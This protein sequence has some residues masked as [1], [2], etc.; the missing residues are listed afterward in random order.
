MSA[1]DPNLKIGAYADLGFIHTASRDYTGIERVAAGVHKVEIEDENI[2]RGSKV[3]A[4]ISELKEDDPDPGWQP[5]SGSANFE[6]LSVTPTT[7]NLIVKFRHDHPRELP[8]RITYVAFNA[9]DG[10][11]R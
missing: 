5:H 9:S 10:R 11:R 4:S 3:V 6:I 2:E 7:L 1:T 8:F